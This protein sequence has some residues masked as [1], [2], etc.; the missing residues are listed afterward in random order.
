M[1]SVRRPRAPSTLGDPR[2]PH[3]L[4]QQRGQRLLPCSSC[5]AYSAAFYAARVHRAHGGSLGVS[6][7]LVSSV[8]RLISRRSGCLRAFRVGDTKSKSSRPRL[9][10]IMQN[11][12][13][14]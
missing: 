11:M 5:S 1:G 9:G 6:G 13:I 14:E 7:D 3:P 4:R 8:P 12:D 10:L 2:T